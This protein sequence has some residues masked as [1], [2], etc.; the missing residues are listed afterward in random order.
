MYVNQSHGRLMQ[1]QETFFELFKGT[2]SISNYMQAIKTQ[3]NAS[4]MTN[5]PFDDEKI[6]FMY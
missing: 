2:K 4:A 1:L 5:A 6:I 3:V